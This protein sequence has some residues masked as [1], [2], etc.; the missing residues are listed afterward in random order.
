MFFSLSGLSS[1]EAE[2]VF[3]TYN[4]ILKE[5]REKELER[6]KKEENDKKRKE[7]YDMMAKNPT[8]SFSG[9][10]AYGTLLSNLK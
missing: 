2:I 8:T 4:K 3:K 7:I 5:G 9:M 10:M 1:E 6:K